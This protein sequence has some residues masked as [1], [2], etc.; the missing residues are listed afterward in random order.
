MLALSF[1]S[2][3]AAVSAL[4]VQTPEMKVPLPLGDITWAAPSEHGNISFTGRHTDVIAQISDLHP[5]WQSNQTYF[6]EL[7]NSTHAA[8]T[9]ETALAKR[10]NRVNQYCS[11]WGTGFW[12]TSGVTTQVDNL[13]YML[14]HYGTGMCTVGARTCGRFSCS[15]NAALLLCST[16]TIQSLH[17]H[18]E[19]T[20]LTILHR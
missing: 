1:L 17:M 10:S 9:A 11:Q 12:E 18:A 7:I 6:H 5:R 15:Y 13:S 4:A 16:Y 2:F 19:N 20:V 14:Q 3:A 8:L